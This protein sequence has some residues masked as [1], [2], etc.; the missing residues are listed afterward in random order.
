MLKNNDGSFTIEEADLETDV[1]TE[2][3]IPENADEQLKQDLQTTIAKKKAW[4]EKAIDPSTQKSYKELYESIKTQKTDDTV[5]KKETVEVPDDIRNDIN[6][7]KEESQKRIFQFANKLS[8][9][10][11]D[12][13]FAYAKGMGLQPKDALDKPFIKKVLEQLSSDEEA[14]NASLSPSR[15]AP[16]QIGGKTF[17]DMTPDERK[18]AFPSITKR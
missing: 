11:V 5:T 9:S 4:R 8:P 12:E 3:V 7:L 6:T 1:D 10:Q 17:K 2:I 16:A 15:R 14:S 13:V 18:N